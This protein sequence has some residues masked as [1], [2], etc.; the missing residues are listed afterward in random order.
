MARSLADC[1]AV[2][3]LIEFGGKPIEVRALRLIDLARIQ[4]WLDAPARTAGVAD[5]TAL[6]SASP[7]DR[8]L[9]AAKGLLRLDDLSAPFGSPKADDRLRTPAGAL[10]IAAMA[11]DLPDSL[12]LELATNASADEFSELLR[13][14][15][16]IEP[17]GVFERLVADVPR[18]NDENENDDDEGID[19]AGIL[20]KLASEYGWTPTQIGALTLNELAIYLDGGADPTETFAS[21]EQALPIARERQALFARAREALDAEANHDG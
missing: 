12:L 15:F 5:L 18:E 3:R 9:L 6:E 16:G 17:R 19:W 21:L 14:A 7:E 2:P 13:A 1:L 10:L 20:R 4:S 11:T 8:R